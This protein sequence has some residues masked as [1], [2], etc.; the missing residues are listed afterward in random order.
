LRSTQKAQDTNGEHSMLWL[1]IGGIFLIGCL[2]S[3]FGTMFVETH[4]LQEVNETARILPSADLCHAIDVLDE[5][6]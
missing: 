5:E 3:F 2:L 6:E 4:L 1:L